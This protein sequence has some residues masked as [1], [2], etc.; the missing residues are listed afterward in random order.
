MLLNFGFRFCD[1]LLTESLKD[2]TNCIPDDGIPTCF[3]CVGTIHLAL[4]VTHFF[5]LDY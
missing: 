2:E 4:H 1:R 5:Q 3:L